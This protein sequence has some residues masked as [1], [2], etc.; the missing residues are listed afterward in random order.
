MAPLQLVSITELPYTPSRVVIPKVPEVCLPA[1][2]G[3]DLKEV[4]MTTNS[5]GVQLFNVG[6]ATHIV[7]FWRAD[8]F[9]G[10]PWP[11]FCVQIHIWPISGMKRTRRLSNE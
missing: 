10:E 6:H 7:W 11:A 2:F 5:F 1:I 4:F 3:D 9:N 8:S